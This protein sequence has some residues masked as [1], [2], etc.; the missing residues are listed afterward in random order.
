MFPKAASEKILEV[1]Y[2]SNST[3]GKF[4]IGK[5]VDS[6]IIGVL[7]FIILAVCKMPYAILVSVIVGITNIIPFFWTF[8]RSSAFVYNNTVCFTY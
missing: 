4:L 1:S 3:F 5:I 8:H 7:T 2:M 6:A